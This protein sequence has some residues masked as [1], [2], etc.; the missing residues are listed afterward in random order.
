MN[1]NEFLTLSCG[2][3]LGLATASSFILGCGGVHHVQ[4]ML[5]DDRLRLAKSDFLV[6]KNSRSEYRRYV[7]TSSADLDYPIVVY[8]FS[9]TD[10]SALLLRCSHQGTELDVRGDLLVCPA[11]G[12][13]FN[14]RGRVV[15]GP[16]A[17][18]LN[19]FSVSVNQDGVYIHLQ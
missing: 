2:A 13:E 14:V 12:S 18:D 11:H 16:A 8:R 4:G 3:C 6:I 17:E 15:H 7:V 5:V 9:E 1:R 19:S 10:F